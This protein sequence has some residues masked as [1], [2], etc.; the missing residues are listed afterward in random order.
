MYV[1]DNP[2]DIL[3]TIRPGARCVHVLQLVQA[4]SGHLLLPCTEYENY[5][6]KKKPLRFHADFTQSSL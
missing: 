2:N 3:V 1:C 5:L 6:E 4:P